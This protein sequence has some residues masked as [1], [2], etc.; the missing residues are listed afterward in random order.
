MD[1]LS[2]FLARPEGQPG[3]A[4]F[5]FLCPA[6]GALCWSDA[7]PAWGFTLGPW[8]GCE[9]ASAPAPEPAPPA[10]HFGLATGVMSVPWVKRSGSHLWR[11]HMAG[12]WLALGGA[13][14]RFSDFEVRLWNDAPD[15]GPVDHAG[16]PM[17]VG[18]G[19]TLA[20]ALECAFN[21]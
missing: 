10:M 4:A 12:Q 9:P 18:Y 14:P 6:H 2:A 11:A 17:A 15:M 20:D 5:S 7:C 8:V 3:P 13:R 16:P 21:S 1:S 19:P